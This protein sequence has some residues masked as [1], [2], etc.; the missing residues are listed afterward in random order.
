MPEVEN[1]FGAVGFLQRERISIINDSEATISTGDVYNTNE[2]H[3][4][5]L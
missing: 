5:T 1:R 4:G 3:D 2:Q